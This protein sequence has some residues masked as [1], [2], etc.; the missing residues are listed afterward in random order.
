VGEILLLKESFMNT[1][2]RSAPEGPENGF[3]GQLDDLGRRVERARS[4]EALTA[5][6][7]TLLLD[8]ETAHE[9]LRVANDEVLAQQ[10]E[11]AGLLSVQRLLRLRN[12]RMLASLPVPAVTTDENGL[13]ESVNAA[14]VGLLNVGADRLLRKPVFTF[15]RDGD[16]RRLRDVLAEATRGGGSTRWATTLLPRHLEPRPA[17]LFLSVA[18]EVES[19]VKVTWLFVTSSGLVDGALG[20]DES[21]LPTALLALAALDG[22]ESVEQLVPA[23]A[24]LCQGALARGVGVGIVVG[25]ANEP[26]VAA[27]SADARRLVDAQLE[28]REG[29]LLEAGADGRLVSTHDVRR[30][31]RWPGLQAMLSD[32]DLGR[33]VAAPLRSGNQVVGSLMLCGRGDATLDRRLVTACELLAATVSGLLQ[34]LGFHDELRTQASDMRKALSSRAV[35]DQAKGIVMADRHVSADEAFEHLGARSTSAPTRYLALSG[36]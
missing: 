27:S 11:I 5:D 22:T 14:A 29:P 19:R 13:I 24:D 34:E 10:E 18:E 9:E 12:E 6:A 15:V 31:P 16:N 17:E 28:S 1:E 25:L 36:G 20:H 3:L 30:D 4:G 23:V 2:K 32:T 8:L 7:A 35:I 21:A 26:T 33:A